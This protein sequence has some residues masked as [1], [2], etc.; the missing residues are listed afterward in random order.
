MRSMNCVLCNARMPN[1]GK[2]RSLSKF[3]GGYVHFECYNKHK[4]AKYDKWIT[5]VGKD[6]YQKLAQLK[7]R[8]RRLGFTNEDYNIQNT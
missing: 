1:G 6:S 5:S 8:A 7:I 4:Q 3:R 2:G